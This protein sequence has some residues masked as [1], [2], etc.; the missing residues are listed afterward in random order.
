MSFYGWLQYT[1]SVFPLKL[2][3]QCRYLVILFFC[4]C[5]GALPSP[6]ESVV[7]SLAVKIML[8]CKTAVFVG[9]CPLWKQYCQMSTD[10]NRCMVYKLP[11]YRP[12]LVDNFSF[13]MW[14]A[15]IICN[16]TTI[17]IKYITVGT[18]QLLS[19]WMTALLSLLISQTQ[20][21]SASRWPWKKR[22]RIRWTTAPA[23]RPLGTLQFSMSQKTPTGGKFS[24]PLFSGDPSK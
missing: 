15:L 7:S 19:S 10:G 6:T 13:R 22:L 20:M 2:Q 17:K 18:W 14:M 24:G 3:Y 16:G 1:V 9:S 11:S 4:F 21:N 12:P 5:R 23:E 8:S